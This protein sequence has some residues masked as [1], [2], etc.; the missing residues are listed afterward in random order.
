[1]Y[2]PLEYLVIE[3]TGNKFNGNILPT[4]EGIV[5]KGIIRIVDLLFIKKDAAGNVTSLE[6][7]DLIAEEL[8]DLRDLTGEVAGLFSEEDIRL[9]AAQLDNDSAA[10]L[11]LFEHTWAIGLR[12]AVT[13]SHGRIVAEERVPVD[14]VVAAVAE[15]DAFASAQG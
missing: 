10:A 3:F 8:P 6:Y 15:A 9:T 1:M 4:L 5:D 12:D 2:G 13:Q 11:M 7:D 14:M